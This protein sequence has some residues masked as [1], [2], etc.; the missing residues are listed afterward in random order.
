MGKYSKYDKYGATPESQAASAA[1][2]G[3]IRKRRALYSVELAADLIRDYLNNGGNVYALESGS[4]GFGL[5]ICMAAGKKT[6]VIREVYINEWASAE[7]IR[8][9]SKTPKKY[10]DK[11]AKNREEIEEQTARELHACGV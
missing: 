3:T 9:Y 4:L 11:I 1:N 7:K 10:A 2:I 5:W 6:A 8:F